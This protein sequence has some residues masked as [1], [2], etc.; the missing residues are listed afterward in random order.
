MKKSFLLISPLFIGLTMLSISCVPTRKLKQAQAK[1]DQ[2]KTDSTNTHGS[3][4]ACNVNVKNLQDERARLQNDK[5]GLLDEKTG[6]E[7]EKSNIQND[8]N[9]L[10]NS[11]KMTIE[12]QAKRLQNLQNLFQAQKDVVNKLK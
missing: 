11:S 2:L 10:S 7:K 12:D 1:I 4:D 5:A 6:L 9:N 3:L 8:L